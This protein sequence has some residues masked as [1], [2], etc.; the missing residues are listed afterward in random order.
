MPVCPV[1]A[2]PVLIMCWCSRG[3]GGTSIPAC[4]L[5]AK[6]II[7]YMSLPSFT[8]SSV[9][10]CTCCVFSH[11]ICLC[12]LCVKPVSNNV[13]PRVITAGCVYVCRFGF[14]P[15]SALSKYL[16]YFTLLL[17]R[18]SLTD[19]AVENRQQIDEDGDRQPYT[20]SGLVW[21]HLPDRADIRR[22]GIRSTSTYCWSSQ[23][24]PVSLPCR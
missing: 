13:P 19:C 20:V 9:Y 22:P 5:W 17:T 21:T 11:V 24:T 10:L 1:S 6:A 23:R 14:K 8:F 7:K 18:C 15:D 12:V 3:L 4:K 2:G 16:H